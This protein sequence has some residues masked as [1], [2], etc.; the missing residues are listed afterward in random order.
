MQNA[1]SVEVLKELKKVFKRNIQLEPELLKLYKEVKKRNLTKKELAQYATYKRSFLEKKYSFILQAI[2]LSVI[3]KDRM[4][5]EPK[6]DVDDIYVGSLFTLLDIYEESKVDYFLEGLLIGVKKCLESSKKSEKRNQLVAI[7]DSTL[8]KEK[9]DFK[10]IGF[11]SEAISFFSIDKEENSQKTNETI[12]TPIEE[13]VD[14]NTETKNK[15]EIAS[16]DITLEQIIIKLIEEME[17]STAKK[18][19]KNDR[20]FFIN[21]AKNSFEKYMNRSLEHLQNQIETLEEDNKKKDLLLDS[22]FKENKKK[23]LLLDFLVKENKKKDLQLQ[24]LEKDVKSLK[25][26]R[27]LYHS[28]F[29]ALKL[30]K[31]CNYLLLTI[32]ET[33]FNAFES[34]Y[35]D[36]YRDKAIKRIKLKNDINEFVIC[37]NGNVI[38]DYIYEIRD[39]TNRQAHLEEEY[40]NIIK[41]TLREMINIVENKE[42]VVEFQSSPNERFFQIVTIKIG[43]AHV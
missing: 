31:I 2:E 12:N 20:D 43:R 1:E 7:S 4:N 30:R 29:V 42:I 37:D 28:Y 25:D 32:F 6:K 8:L 19:A 26:D 16:E 41:I 24:K 9:N 14:N 38:I 40:G 11:L 27:D 33:H 18:I 36:N 17:K 35:V 10:I 34:E 22:L 39:N 3:I 21:L 23:D 13:Q 5:N 15:K